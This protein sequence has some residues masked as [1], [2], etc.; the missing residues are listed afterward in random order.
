[1]GSLVNDRVPN[2]PPRFKLPGGPADPKTPCGVGESD[3]EPKLLFRSWPLT[4]YA[5]AFDWLAIVAGRIR[6]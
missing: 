2:D 1:M 6:S 5:F 3:F 4:H